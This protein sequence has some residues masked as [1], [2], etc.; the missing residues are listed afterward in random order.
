MNIYFH[1][2]IDFIFSYVRF[3]PDRLS[4][5]SVPYTVIGTG[6]FL[7]YLTN[8][9]KADHFE[10]FGSLYNTEKGTFNNLKLFKLLKLSFK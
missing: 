8:I 6:H 7:S 2:F 10:L 1:H 3:N 5:R 9:T 4:K